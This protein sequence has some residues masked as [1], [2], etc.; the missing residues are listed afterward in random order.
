MDGVDCEA[1]HF[2]CVSCSHSLAG[3]PVRLL[4]VVV[5]VECQLITRPFL[6]NLALAHRQLVEPITD[7]FRCAAAV[8][9]AVAIGVALAYLTV[10][11]AVASVHGCRRVAAATC[12]RWFVPHRRRHNWNAGRHTD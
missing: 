1:K 3:F 5:V 4:L 6:S 10:A 7:E 2:V 9:I 12:L 8:A 11:V